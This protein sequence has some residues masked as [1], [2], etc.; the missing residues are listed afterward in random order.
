MPRSNRS[1]L[2]GIWPNS[3]SSASL[4]ISSRA[5]SAS[6]SSTTTP[7]RSAASIRACRNAS[8]SRSVVRESLTAAVAVFCGS[9]IACGLFLTGEIAINLSVTMFGRKDH[10]F[11]IAYLKPGITRG[12]TRMTGWSRRLF[13]WAASSNL[14]GRHPARLF[15][16]RE[17]HSGLVTVL[18]RDR[19]PSFLGL[20]AALERA[21]NLGRAFHQLVEVHR[22]ELAADHPEIASDRH[23]HLL[24]LSRTGSSCCERRPPSARLHRRNIPCDR[25]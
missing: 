5:T 4:R 19:A 21:L 10:L 24:L 20:G 14:S 22:A 9:D 8:R 7:A 6:R 13:P 11:S 16:D 17:A 3:G 12:P 1:T 25:R 2:S 15:D 18:F 23:G